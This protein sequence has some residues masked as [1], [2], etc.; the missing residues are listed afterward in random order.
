MFDLGHHNSYLAF[1]GLSIT[2]KT[3]FI[4]TSLV[5]AFFAGWSYHNI[6][7]DK[8]VTPTVTLDPAIEQFVQ[9]HLN[10][11]SYGPETF[12]SDLESLID[13]KQFAM[14][15]RLLDSVRIDQQVE[16]DAGGCYY[17]IGGNTIRNPGVDI[18]YE[19][20]RDYMMPGT[21]CVIESFVWVDRACRFAEN[22]NS[23]R[24]DNAK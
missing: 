3:L 23:Y 24:S 5:A 9:P 6:S 8:P 10:D 15:I 4:G 16:H 13:T 19:R 2:I 7:T 20:Q 21:G 12:R 18:S 1:V 17:S 11:V 14:A 22:Y